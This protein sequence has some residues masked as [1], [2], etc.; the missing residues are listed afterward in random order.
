M[1]VVFMG[2]PDFAVPALETIYRSRHEL[3]AVFTQ[4]DRAAGRGRALRGSPVKIAAASMGLTVYQPE[5]LRHPL[6]A[7]TIAGYRPDVLVVVAYGRILP[8]AILDLP[9]HGGINLHASLLP[10][11]RG[12]APIQR[13]I[14]NGERATGVTIMH[15]TR[16]LD[17]GDII[18]QRAVDIGP[19]DT[20]GTL[21]DRLARLGAGLLVPAL[22]LLE[23]GTA[24]RSPQ[25]GELATYAPALRR[26]DERVDWTEP[27]R[28]VVDRIRALD[29]SP[30][31]HT[32]HRGRMLK[33]WKAALHGDRYAAGSLGEER[34]EPGTVVAVRPDGSMLVAAGSELVEVKEVQ[35][36]NGKRMPAAAYANGS[37]LGPGTVLGN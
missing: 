36:A 26:E 33:L 22:D 35:P 7:E 27:G 13:A 28:R 31:A 20:G 24:P 19:L 16:D 8:Q 3:L 15:M 10:K 12:A 14:M 25:A 37:G 11:Y 34:L 9:P 29:P 4:P 6:I 23:A 18:L 21:H 1:R 32:A 5:D 2:T 30:G 17:A